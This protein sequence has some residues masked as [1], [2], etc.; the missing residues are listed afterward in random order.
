MLALHRFAVPP[1]ARGG[2]G[3]GAV[4][5]GDPG[6]LPVPPGAAIPAWSV[7]P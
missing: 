3:R 1:S 6:V 7:A 5:A 4:V 2:V